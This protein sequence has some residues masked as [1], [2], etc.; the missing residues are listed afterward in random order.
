M[1][2]SI[3]QS[4]CLIVAMVATLAIALTAIVYGAVRRIVIGA[5]LFV[6]LY[7]DCAGAMA[8]D[9]YKTLSGENCEK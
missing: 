3:L 6:A 7:I 1:K 8:N 2:K 9:I 4:F 5:P